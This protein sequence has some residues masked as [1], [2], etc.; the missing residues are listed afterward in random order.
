MQK[1]CLRAQSCSS[2][3][4]S[5][6][7]SPTGSSVHRVIPAGMAGTPER[8]AISSSQGSSPPRD[9][10]PV[11][12]SSCT[13]QRILHLSHL[14]RPEFVILLNLNLTLVFFS[15]AAAA[16]KSLQSC[17]ALCDPIDGSLPG[18]SRPWD[19][20]GKNSRLPKTNFFKKVFFGNHEIQYTPLKKK[21]KNKKTKKQKQEKP[22][23]NNS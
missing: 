17:S 1:L 18:S 3:C 23:L 20:P 7:C 4:D 5:L 2:L 22:C 14:G 12:F 16:A 19:S 11:S 15:S 9:G 21:T 8:V 13:G 6:D 10:A